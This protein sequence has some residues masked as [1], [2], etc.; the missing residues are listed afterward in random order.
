MITNAS[1]LR[2]G[3]DIGSTTVKAVVMDKQ[4]S[5]MLFSAYKRHHACQA[6][7]VKSVLAGI[8]AQFPDARFRAAVCGSGGKPI[9]DAIG[10][11]Y[12][13]EVVANAVAVR[14]FYPQAR[15][16]VELGGQDAKI[17]FFY[18]DEHTRR[19]TASDMRMN[20]SCAGGTGAFIDEIAALLRVPVEE[21]E[22]L[23]ARGNAVYEISG[24]CGVFAKTDI[25][26]LFNQG[27]LPE[28]IALSTFHAIAKQTIGG[29][30]QGLEL[31]PPI[32]FEGGPL[33]FN[34]TLIRVFAERLG[35]G[36]GDCIRPENP[37]TFIAYGAA[38]SVDAMFADDKRQ[39]DMAGSLDALS[40]VHGDTGREAQDT[41]V[42]DFFSSAEE[43]ADFDKRH[44]LPPASVYAGKRGETL[45]VY[46]GI[47]AGSTTSK[48]VLLDE[49]ERVVDSF[50]SN[51]HGEPLRVIQKGLL[52][53]KR[54]YDE[55]GVKLEIA[56]VG[57]TGYGELLFA[58]AFGADYHTVET[59][60]HAAA[61][62]HFA[63]E[64]SFILDIGGQDMKAISI[65]DG[66]VT[67]ITVN[68]ACSS[69]CGSFL[70]HCANTLNIPLGKVAEA[71]FGAKN[72]AELGSRCTVFMNSTIITEQK[73]GRQPD[74]IMAGLC[75][76]IIENVFTK[77]VRLSNF[78]ALGGN[79]V[80]Q[81]GT[82]RNDAV[83]RAIEQYIGR[84]VVR[85]P[86]PG[87]MGAMGIALLTKRR[88]AENGFLTGRRK[89]GGKTLFI[90]FDALE[91]F[92]YSQESD[93]RCPFCSN[94]CSR[95]LVRF[96][97]GLT[98][99]TGNRCE[100]GK[101]IGDPKDP[102]LR[103]LLSQVNA[104]MEAVPDMVKLRERLLFRDYPFAPLSPDRDVT[105]GLPRALDFWR[106]MPFFTTFF[107][108]LGFKTKISRPSSRRLFEDGLPFVAS[109]TVCF[110]AKLLHGH[111]HDLAAAGVDRVFMPLFCRL[112][113]L[114]PEP[115][116]TY[117]C[118]VL[119][120]YPLV[121]K[122]SDN[123][124]RRWN[125]P[126]DTPVF[127]WFSKRDRA[128]QLCRYM[129]ETFG[130]PPG[131]CRQAIAQG[132]KALAAFNAEITAEASRVIAQTE[133]SG[134]FAV[135]LAG[136]HYQ[137]DTLVNHNLSQYFT[138]IGI[139]VL[140][141]DSLPGVHKVE[142]DKTRLDIVNNN[143]ALLLAG[144]IIAAE[145]PALEYVELFSFGCGHD[146]LHTDEVTRIMR[147]MSG[148]SPL[149]L[150]LDESDIS[151]PLRIR[152]R[153][154]IETVCLRR[155]QAGE[156]PLFPLSDPYT[157]KYT[158]R[159]RKLKT[160]L[161]PN[162]TPGFSKIIAAALRREGLKAE[163]LPPGGKEAMRYGKRYVHNDSCFPAQMIIGE[164]IAAL[165]NGR[166]DPDKVVVGTGKTTCDCRLVNYMALTRSALDDAGFP[167]VPI[168]STD[169]ADAKNMHPCYRFNQLI[170][171][172]IIWCVIML[173]ILD[174]LRRKIRPYE[175]NAGE[176]DRV[177]E[178]GEYAII[179]ALEKRGMLGALSAYKKAV[180]ALCAVPYDRTVRK[181]LV[182]ITGEYLLVFHSGTNYNIERYLEKNNMEVE[183]P[184][185]Y[186]IYRN[187][188]LFHT[189]SE[190]KDFKVR[191]PLGE[192]LYA[193]GGDAYIDA[194]L[195]LMEKIA[196]RHPLYER[197]PRLAEMA[198]LSDNIIHHSIQSGE[199]FLIA[200]DIL[201]HAAEGVRSFVI[202]QPFG[203]LPNHVC[204]RG[205][206]KPV[207]EV[208]PGIQ[209]LPLD[210]D[211]D[212][213]YANIENRLQ[214]LIMN[215]RTFEEQTKNCG[216]SLRKYVKVAA[217]KK[218]PDIENEPDKTLA[219]EA[220]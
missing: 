33:T 156:H 218:D 200:A 60:A 180:A 63:P 117:T 118:P 113:S 68:E 152:V 39:L 159:D 163:A 185:M 175:T 165:K 98:W 79:I 193:F 114:T 44:S 199:G 164:A 209:V 166:Y 111:L 149:I 212:T 91:T 141:V 206:I 64:A 1:H 58:K 30:A 26:P 214:M 99:L 213:S 21:F 28:D 145:H 146:A 67:N 23:A 101:I 208:Y 97:N 167:Q 49:D 133:K 157:S 210:Y 196:A 47:D 15:V 10:A 220:V 2:L 13:Q 52:G 205:L 32:I 71:A 36:E 120:G 51:N 88:I 24:R 168:I 135:V 104:E 38:L 202:L 151:G 177:V 53:L 110:P 37:E 154:F 138:A 189:I 186:D 184:R 4:Q 87:E 161:V 107:H 108:A 188:M 83:L 173:E 140:T 82:F 11:P 84:P 62:R 6:E 105:I 195:D 183:L 143:H 182:F 75:R 34:P 201:H 109:D 144:A 72:P 100:R 211:P 125:L 20:G 40:S 162:V 54:K 174:N 43:R 176:T 169:F 27:G 171:A 57:T 90:G 216:A 18:Y 203:C 29:L 92:D 179:T 170:Y 194:A 217:Y 130:V 147:E 48:L 25:Q 66:I 153:S 106:T 132:E 129:K 119:K 131:L 17:V 198:E 121:V 192:M 123:P 136:R 197:A 7:T 69:G 86:Y 76:S 8:K 19:L 126:M 74:D 122:Y 160:V 127:H 45:R 142:L 77:V 73:N 70:E 89:D 16:A 219:M 14:T 3:L 116:S 190:I 50:Y 80:V 187:L 9:A 85:A 31:T 124:G 178:T 78:A 155:K 81:G 65:N 61:A 5:K 134:G 96:S 95:I 46:L 128:V 172:K 56:A 102:A 191:H 22:A 204:G 103:K 42:P 59:V 181:N 215:A 112:P 115:E 137:Y 35:L 93:V 55:A 41:A 150:K 94:N 139:P 158:R 12:V 148:K 207:K